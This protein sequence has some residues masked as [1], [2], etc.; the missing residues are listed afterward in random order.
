MHTV[1]QRASNAISNY[2]GT[3]YTIGSSSNLLYEAS[4]GLDD[5]AYGSL[6]IPLS[7]TVELPGNG[8][9]VPSHEILHIG[10]ETYA[11]FVEFIRHVSLF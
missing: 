8:F 11:G 5:W 6:G 10:R 2:R 7:Y 9:S 1:A 4:G 3:R